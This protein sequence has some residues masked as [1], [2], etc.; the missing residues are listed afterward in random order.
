[1]RTMNLYFV[2]TSRLMVS[3]VQVMHEK[4][5][6]LVM[7]TT[8]QEVIFKLTGILFRADIGAQSRSTTKLA[9][10]TVTDLVD[11]LRHG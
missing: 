2:V 8:P 1:M 3:A 4:V 9:K 6:K 5:T 10:T 11:A 7:Q